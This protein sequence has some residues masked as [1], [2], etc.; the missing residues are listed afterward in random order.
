MLVRLGYV[1]ITKTIDEI[2]SFRA[3]NYTNYTKDIN[4]NNINKIIDKN[5][6]ILSHIIDYNIKNNIHFYRITSALI[7]LAT[8]DDV[9]F[10]YITPFIDK[11]EEIKNKISNSNMRVDMHPN[12][13][14]VLNSNRKEVVASTFKILAYHS[15]IMN[16]LNINNPILILH[17]GSSAMGKKKSITRFKNNFLKLPS[18]TKKMIAVENDDKVYDIEDTLSLCEEL[19]IPMV[20]D[21][22]HYICN[23][24]NIDLKNYLPRI[25]KTWNTTPKMHFSTPKSNNKKDFRSHNDYINVDNFIEMLNIIKNYTPNIDIMIE[26]KMKDV[27]LFRLIRELKYK[28]NYKF[29]DETTFIVD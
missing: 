29:I 17:V 13:Y 21:Y 2:S 16:I 9:I 10:D 28:S 26:A 4:I 27:A 14:A 1:S 18:D 20:L 12:E 15:D 23:K 5:L 7:P 24:G 3:L 11:Y 22:H 6:D 8:K 25:F 19:N